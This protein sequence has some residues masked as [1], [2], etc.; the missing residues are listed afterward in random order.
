MVYKKTEKSSIKIAKFRRE[1]IVWH[2]VM[3]NP[4]ICQNALQS[5]ASRLGPEYKMSGES[6]LAAIKGLISRG[7]VHAE[8]LGN[9]VHYTVRDPNTRSLQR[10]LDKQLSEAEMLARAIRRDL[11][12]FS[13]I[14]RNTVLIHF[15][16]ALRNLQACVTCL[17]YSV[18]Y[19]D[20]IK[21]QERIKN[22]HALAYSLLNQ[23]GQPVWSLALGVLDNDYFIKFKQ[24]ANYF[25]AEESFYEVRSRLD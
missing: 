3:E 11:S 6:C 8:K 21:E 24:S 7:M 1:V 9:M 22:L 19:F 10:F 16:Q 14:K 17:S 12:T 5:L 25:S 15:I 18:D 4:N 2:L 23:S 13:N 20:V